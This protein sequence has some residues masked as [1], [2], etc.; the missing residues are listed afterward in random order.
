MIRH[1]RGNA[2]PH[3]PAPPV[4]KPLGTARGCGCN[5]PGMRGF[6]LTIVAVLALML[7]A[8]R[9]PAL[10][11][12]A[13]PEFGL[14]AGQV[15]IGTATASLALAIPLFAA[16]TPFETASFAALVGAP[17]AVGGMVCTLGQTSKHYR[18][19]CLPV[20]AGAYIGALASLPAL[21]IGLS[22]DHGYG[23]DFGASASI[24]FMISYALGT[25][26]G[27]TVA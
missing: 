20:V 27:A 18:G 6:G 8:P 12:D 23:R 16:D 11:A 25:A 1:G 4:E 19:G 5:L 3:V 26:L 7:F 22:N 15:L 13:P 24:A 14:G 17:A 10:A 9:S 2:S 21:A